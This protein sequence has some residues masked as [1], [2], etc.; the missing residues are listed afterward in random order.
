MHGGPRVGRGDPKEARDSMPF[1]L[2][3]ASVTV[4]EHALTAFIAVLDK[5]EAHAAA[6][7]FNADNFLALRLAPDMFPFVRQVQ[8]CCDH[9]KNAAF[10][11][12]GAEPPRIE[13]KEATI[14]E[15]R[16]RIQTTLELVRSV[17][18]KAIDAA[19][20]GEIVFPAG[21]NT[22]LKLPAPSYLMHFVLPNF[23]FHMTTAYDILRAAG[24]EIGK[25]DFLGTPPN[26][27]QV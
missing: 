14:A 26:V 20:D 16:A 9:A 11:L 18:A 25:R 19:A 10:R 7:R 2:H 8:A 24:V 1:S 12:S 23:F 6:R 21:P 13:D 22:R 27:A 15:L 3:Q 4:F 5:A 17:D